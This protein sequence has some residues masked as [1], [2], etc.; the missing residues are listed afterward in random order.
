[1]VPTA[2][3]KVKILAGVEFIELESLLEVFGR[4][5]HQPD[6]AD[7]EAA[8]DDKE[9]SNCH[10]I[11]TSIVVVVLPIVEVSGLHPTISV[12][13]I[14]QNVSDVGDEL[15]KTTKRHG[16]RFPLHLLVLVIEGGAAVVRIQNWEQ[17]QVLPVGNIADRLKFIVKVLRNR[18]QQYS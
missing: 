10:L 13:K 5:H 9:V 17:S 18:N 14:D 16:E 15:N 11:T 1:M 3:D 4:V 12:E 6:E 7:G 8:E 2:E